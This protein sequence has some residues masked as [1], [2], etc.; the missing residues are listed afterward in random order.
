M[1]RLLVETPGTYHHSL[2]VGNLAE[3]AAEAIGADPLLA[4]VAAYYHDIGKLSNPAAFIENQAGGDNIH[5]DLDPETSAQLLKSHVSAGIDIAYKSGLPKALIAFIPQH[6]GTAVMSYFYARAK[7]QA[8][9]PFGGLET[10]EGKKAAEAVDVRKFRH[11][12]PKPQVAGGGDHHARRL[13]GGVRAV[14]RP[15]A[16]RPRSG[17]WSAGSSRSGSPT[18]SSTSATSRC[19]TSR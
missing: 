19:A 17:R 3:R 15:R 16:T 1:R 5:D 4:R 8:A 12:G 6:H 11:G 18:T 13:R 7:E 10:A 14:A 2:M 9:A